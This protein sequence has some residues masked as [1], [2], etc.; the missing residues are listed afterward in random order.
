MANTAEAVKVVNNETTATTKATLKVS[1]KTKVVLN[2]NANFVSVLAYARK[3]WQQNAYATSNNG[4][5]KLLADCYAQYLAMCADS[6]KA[7]ELREQLEAYITTNK[8][9]FRKGTHNLV[10]IVKCCLLYT[11]PSPRDRS[12]SRMPSSA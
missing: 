10:K 5:Y 9:V 1:A 7:K 11:S 2:D 12:V 3:Q 4:L 6:A 8:L